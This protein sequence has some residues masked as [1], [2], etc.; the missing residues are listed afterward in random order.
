MNGL[1]GWHTFAVPSGF[2][3]ERLAIGDTALDLEQT[4]AAA[5]AAQVDAAEVDFLSRNVTGW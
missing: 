3:I 2:E 4:V 1:V 5:I